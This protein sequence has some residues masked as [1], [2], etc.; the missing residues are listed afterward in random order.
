MNIIV[1]QNI[2]NS[3]I[4]ERVFKFLFIIFS[5][6]FGSYEMQD[7]WSIIIN[8]N[9]DENVWEQKLGKHS[10]GISLDSSFTVQSNSVLD[11][12]RIVKL[13]RLLNTEFN[14]DYYTF[15]SS[16]TSIPICW[17]YGQRLSTAYSYHASNYGSTDILL[18][19]A[20]TKSTVKNVIS[21][22]NILLIFLVLWLS[23]LL[24]FVVWQYCSW[25]CKRQRVIEIDIE[26]YVPLSDGYND[27]YEYQS[28]V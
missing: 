3:E 6:G 22:M 27:Y 2:S 1:H 12:K 20:E 16:A 21:A 25:K 15:S 14:A 8:G 13:Q 28:C 10:E 26:G 9:T 18:S 19:S 11:G 23:L 4:Q 7:T 17:A 24:L 5:I